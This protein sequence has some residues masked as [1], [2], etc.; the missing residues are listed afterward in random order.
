MADPKRN[1]LS[2]FLFE[3]MSDS[4]ITSH[5]TQSQTSCCL[6]DKKNTSTEMTVHLLNRFMVTF[7]VLANCKKVGMLCPAKFLKQN[8][9]PGHQEKNNMDWERMNVK[10]QTCVKVSTGSW[11]DIGR[12]SNSQQ[13]RHIFSHDATFS[14][15]SISGCTG[16]ATQWGWRTVT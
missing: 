1:T 10:F 15:F 6:R 12:I 5:I 8:L 14:I 11:E 16:I 9:S 13:E 2:K 4:E 3:F 7:A